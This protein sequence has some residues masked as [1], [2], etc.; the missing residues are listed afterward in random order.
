MPKLLIYNRQLRHVLND[1]F[2]FRIKARDALAGVWVLDKT[3][4]VPDQA[5]NIKLVIENAGAA[6]SI[7]VDRTLGPAFTAGARDA[8]FIQ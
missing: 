4:A 1:P 7:A 2:G 8:T 6:I 3:L 5:A